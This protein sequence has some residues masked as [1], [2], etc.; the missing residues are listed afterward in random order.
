MA[1]IGEEPLSIRVQGAPYAVV[2]RTP[3]GEKAHVA[4]FCLGEG[5]A[6][7]PDDITN[8]AFCDGEDTNVVTVTLTAVRRT[9]IADHLDRRTYISQTSC[10]I[11]GKSIVDDLVQALS[12][13]ADGDP[14]DGNGA[15]NCLLRLGDHQPLRDKT[16]AAHGAAIY[17]HEL[18]Q[19]SVAEDVGR[20]NALDKAIGRL[21]LDRR[22]RQAQLLTLSS[23]ISYELVQKTARAKIPIILAISR[24]TALAVELATALNM[25][26][27]SLVKGGSLMIYC[28]PHRLI[29][30]RRT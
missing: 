9:R 17:D 25:T 27:G 24:P 5:I 22:L 21:F 14:L 19:L 20:H 28:N 13:V 15:L 18:H 3:G 1:L 23:R 8:I 11:C 26:L 29:W 30:P 10:G 7:A 6:D 2:M 4:G 12:P 16:R